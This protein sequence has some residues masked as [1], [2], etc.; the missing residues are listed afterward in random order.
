MKIKNR[1]LKDR[2]GLEFRSSFFAIIAIGLVIVA[3]GIIVTDWSG[4]YGA[5]ISYDLGE[6]DNANALKIE[7][8]SQK[9]SISVKS[10]ATGDTDFE[11]TSLRG[12]F[13]LLN[14]IY[15]PF[16]IVF[17]T[18]GMIISIIDR[19][20]APPYIKVALVTLMMMSI[21]F[22]LVTILFKIPRSSA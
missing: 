2:R 22:A 10:P 21:T 6:Y 7:A 16:R 14:N 15:K 9:D 4:D 19:F 1:L 5:G 18:G 12:V 11:G 13:G 17:G 8:E 20:G 3:A